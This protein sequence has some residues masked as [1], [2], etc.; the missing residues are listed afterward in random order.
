MK[1]K[2]VLIAAVLLAMV[3]LPCLAQDPQGT[4]LAGLQ[5]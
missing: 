4:Q 5:E 1:V 2:S 3:S